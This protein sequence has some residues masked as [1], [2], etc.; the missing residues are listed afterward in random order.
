MKVVVWLVLF[1]SGSKS[2]TLYVAPNLING[3]CTV[4]G[5]T[6]NQ[7]YTFEQLV[8]SGILVSSFHSQQLFF[9]P[10]KHVLPENQTLKANDI[11]LALRPWDESQEVLIECHENTDIIFGES[12]ELKISISSLHFTY[13][14]MKFSMEFKWQ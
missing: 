14:T 4:N 11:E 5:T 13:C 3:Q 10:G 1:I 9:L 6:L 7:C 8:I 2:Q 12:V